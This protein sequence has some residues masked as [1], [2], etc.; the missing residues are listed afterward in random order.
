M[1]IP[2]T[3][4]EIENSQDIHVW[5]H[6]LQN[7]IR[8]IRSKPKSAQKVCVAL[9]NLSIR[10]IYHQDLTVKKRGLQLLCDLAYD[11]EISKL[12]DI[13]GPELGSIIHVLIQDKNKSHR[14]LAKE[15]LGRWS[16]NENHRITPV[17]RVIIRSVKD[18]VDIL[19]VCIQDAVIL[20]IEILG[21]V[22]FFIDEVY[23]TAYS[24]TSM[25]CLVRLVQMVHFAE[26]NHSDRKIWLNY[27]RQ[28]LKH[29]NELMTTAEHQKHIQKLFFSE[30]ITYFQYDCGLQMMDAE[31]NNLEPKKRFEL[32][33]IALVNHL[34][35]FNSRLDTRAQIYDEATDSC[36]IMNAQM[37]SRLYA[38]MTE[39]LTIPLVHALKWAAGDIDKKT[40]DILANRSAAL[41]QEKTRI[42][43][44]AQDQAENLLQLVMGCVTRIEKDAEK[45][46]T[47]DWLHEQ[48]CACMVVES[49]KYL[50]SQDVNELIERLRIIQ[51][52]TFA[53]TDTILTRAAFS[54]EDS[55]FSSRSKDPSMPDSTNI[56]IEPE[57]DSYSASPFGAIH[58]EVFGAVDGI[59]W[60]PSSKLSAA[61]VSGAPLSQTVPFDFKKE[62][63]VIPSRESSLS[64]AIESRPSFRMSGGKFRQLRTTEERL[65]SERMYP[66]NDS[67]KCP[68]MF[69]PRNSGNDGPTTEESGDDPISF[70]R[71]QTEGGT[72][73]LPTPVKEFRPQNGAQ[74]NENLPFS[75]S[76]SAQSKPVQSLNPVFLPEEHIDN[77]NMRLAARKTVAVVANGTAS[78]T[79]R[80]SNH[81]M[82]LPNIAVESIRKPD[83][84]PI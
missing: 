65:E 46:E 10:A 79:R 56:P 61:V 72:T 33:L 63:T 51:E 8:L 34:E 11:E 59:E 14:K 18:S 52:R 66:V 73:S 5:S 37:K 49:A 62:N 12:W 26:K 76:M 75:R 44:E 40:V 68:K 23:E 36:V 29:R 21:D 9:S 70:S 45:E 30:K 3:L 25:Y 58:G 15:T 47:S 41:L 55:Q 82:I 64:I 60:E 53:G 16:G 69:T 2:N 50:A 22:E 39:M 19:D 83:N 77:Y 7:L 67:L 71:A 13:N 38:H 27:I 78:S 32:V 54:H 1:E 74:N 20:C 48:L 17:C 43:M 31:E 80:D 28:F 35:D 6:G 84:I 81:K 4:H 42:T 24:D 57:S